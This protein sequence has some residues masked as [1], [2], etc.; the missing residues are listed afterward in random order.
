M[1]CVEPGDT[2]GDGAVDLI[3]FGGLQACFTGPDGPVY[4]PV[5][6]PECQCADFDGDGDV[7]AADF[8]SFHLRIGQ[9][10]P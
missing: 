7:D 8:G 9:S 5:Y 4:P 6:G 2:S 1:V 3:D 10:I